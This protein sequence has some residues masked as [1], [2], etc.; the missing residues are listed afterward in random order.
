MWHPHPA[1]PAVRPPEEVSPCTDLQAEAGGL[2]VPAHLK[3]CTLP[4][5]SPINTWWLLASTAVTAAPRSNVPAMLA[6]CTRA[7][8]LELYTSIVPAAL[9]TMTMLGLSCGVGVDASVDVDVDMGV[10][11]GVD[12]GVYAAMLGLIRGPGCGRE[13]GNGCGDWLQRIRAGG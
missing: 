1:H 11:T 5:W 13:C 7:P 9:P 12:T 6:C 2:L 3:R 8:T 10:D 4:L